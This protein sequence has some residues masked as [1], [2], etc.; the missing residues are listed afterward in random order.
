MYNEVTVKTNPYPKYE[1]IKLPNPFSSTPVFINNLKFKQS[2]EKLPI[3]KQLL[4]N[5]VQRINDHT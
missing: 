5:L 4:N 2:A 3:K 1:M